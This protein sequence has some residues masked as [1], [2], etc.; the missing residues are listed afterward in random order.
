MPVHPCVCMAHVRKLCVLIL[1][2]FACIRMLPDLLSLGGSHAPCDLQQAC[3]AHELAFCFSVIL[4]LIMKVVPRHCIPSHTVQS[5]STSTGLN[6]RREGLTVVVD[7]AANLL[8][9]KQP[10]YPTH[11]RSS[12]SVSLSAMVLGALYVFCTSVLA[13]VGL[14]SL[15]QR[16]WDVRD[17]VPHTPLLA[18]AAPSRPGIKVSCADVRLHFAECC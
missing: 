4:Y 1:H 9:M 5:M 3:S 14:A 12:G 16:R 8:G 10:V 6:R 7:S 18:E 11:A 17:C 13:G 15:L 2:D